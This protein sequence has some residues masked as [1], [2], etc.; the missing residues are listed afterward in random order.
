MMK[1]KKNIRTFITIN[2]KVVTKYFYNKED[3][4]SWRQSVR[5][6]LKSESL[7]GEIWKPIPQ[8]LRYMAS[9]MG[10]LISLNYKNS[11]VNKIITPCI[12]GGY[13]QTMIKSDSGKYHTRK[14]HYLVAL[15]FMGV[16]KENTEVNH[17]DGNK[18][19]NKLDNLEY[20]T[21]SENVKHSYDIGLSKAM[22][23]SKNGNSKLTDDQVRYIRECKKNKGRFWGREQIAKELNIS[24]AHVK[25][26]ANSKTL[27]KHISV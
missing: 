1:N 19:N 3:A 25:D 14:V 6:S 27:W 15:A 5:D 18:L 22:T 13:Y 17:I 8:Y 12:T 20:I 9:N 26:I 10:R 4:E 11:G 16:R 23:G 7:E 21:H 24:S 2:S